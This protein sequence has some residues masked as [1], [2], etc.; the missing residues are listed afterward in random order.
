MI[1]SQLHRQLDLLAEMVDRYQGDPVAFVRDVL[2]NPDTRAAFELYDAEVTFLERGFTI[3]ASGVLAFP[4]LLYAAPKKS[5]KTTFAAIAVVYVVAIL[6]GPYAEG[7]IVANDLEQ[8]QGRVFATVVRIIENSPAL[9]A[10][11]RSA[12]GSRVEF[13]NGASITA[14]A[15]DYAGAAGAN[16]NIT[17]FDELWG[18]TSERSYRL[19]DEMVPVPTRLVSVR[20]TVTYAG[21]EGES[22]LLEKEY[23]RGAKGAVVAPALYQGDG[24]LMFWSH[25]PVA[26]WQTE[27]WLAQMRE[28]LRPSAY[29][30]MIENRFVGSVGEFV[31]LEWWDAATTGR[32]AV[33]APQIA[34]VLGIDASLKRDTAAIVVTSWDPQ[35]QK[36]IVLDHR[37]F[38]P[39]GRVALDLEE[40]LEAGVLDIAQRFSIVEARYDPWQFARSAQ[41]LAKAGIP[42]AEYPQSMPKLTA[43]S[44]NLYELL[45]SGNL[46]AYP[47]ADLRRA[48]QNAVVVES[49]RGMKIAKEKTANKIDLAVA[50]A[51]SALGSVEC[52]AFTPEEGTVWI[53]PR[54]GDL[55]DVEPLWNNDPFSMYSEPR[56]AELEEPGWGRLQS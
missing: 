48:L 50:L 4:E 43:M 15:S 28:Q 33:S 11:V 2:I 38:V 9:A 27:A 56:L 31:P 18:Y 10:V 47:D 13:V 30:R 12:T 35:S 6:G 22:V 45:K 23:E 14:I 46:E 7:Y 19:W 21:F 8:A 40:T 39:D 3:D 51:I 53:D 44:T 49:S 17:V 55:V 5:G 32:R 24:R 20:L 36:V 16:P 25:V 52:F 54:T 29:V 34:V 26:P 41:T 37:I 42:M 1:D